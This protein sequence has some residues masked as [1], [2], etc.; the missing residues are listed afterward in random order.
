VSLDRFNGNNWQ[1]TVTR[2][3]N[4]V[5]SGHYRQSYQLD[6]AGQPDHSHI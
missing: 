1:H 4:S 5:I 3:D 2:G 6:A